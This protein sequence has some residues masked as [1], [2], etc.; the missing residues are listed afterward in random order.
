[1][2]V[3]ISVTIVGVLTLMVFTS[4]RLGARAWEK[5]EREIDGIYRQRV[6]LSLLQEQLTSISTKN[7]AMLNKKPYFLIGNQERIEFLS[8]RQLNPG[9]EEGAVKVVYRVQSDATTG[10]KTLSIREDKLLIPETE[11]K[12]KNNNDDD[13]G[14][15]TL[16]QE[17]QQITIEYLDT[18]LSG[19]QY[20]WM[21]E[22]NG[23]QKNAFPQAVRLRMYKD[24]FE[25][26][27]II[28]KIF[29]G[30]MER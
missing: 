2:E 23:N 13:D 11:R 27:T 18:Q 19:G 21:T 25:Y 20:A 16:V 1:M 24:D 10:M 6:V 9:T 29:V 28:A 12:K 22:W 14:F 17:M 26:S 8:T 3:L 15:R 5:G 7:I 30:D 4:L